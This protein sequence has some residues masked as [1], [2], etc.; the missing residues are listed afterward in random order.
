MESTQFSKQ[1]GCGVCEEGFMDTSKGVAC[2]RPGRDLNSP[3]NAAVATGRTPAIAP[4]STAHCL[5]P[6]PVLSEAGPEPAR[7]LPRRSRAGVRGPVPTR[8]PQST[9]RSTRGEAGRRTRVGLGAAVRAGASVQHTQSRRAGPDFIH[10][11]PSPQDSSSAS[12]EKNSDTHGAGS[13]AP[14]SG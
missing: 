11:P 4:A 3:L 2:T 8:P 7:R 13:R 6:K 12:Q 5:T 14:R 10:L 1:I 9:Q